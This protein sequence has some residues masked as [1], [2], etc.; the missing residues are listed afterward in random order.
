MI[1]A[2]TDMRLQNWTQSF[3]Q[4][5][6]D[7]VIHARVVFNLVDGAHAQIGTG[8]RFLQPGGQA[9]DGNKKSPAGIFQDARKVRM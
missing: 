1:I 7:G 6:F 4:T 5:C 3:Q 2:H 9:G 8:D